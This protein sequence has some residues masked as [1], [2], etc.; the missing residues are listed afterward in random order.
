MKMTKYYVT[1]GDMQI[2]LSAE[3]YFRA[4]VKV[5]Q[6][7]NVP[8]DIPP[9]FIISERG[10]KEHLDD[11]IVSSHVVIAALLSNSPIPFEE[12]DFS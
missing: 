4:C 12:D 1:F 11:E 5:L 7:E 8:C 9:Y 3:N 10:F 6:S 2:T